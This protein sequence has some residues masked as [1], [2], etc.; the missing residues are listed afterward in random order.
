M[1]EGERGV[2]AT[3]D[4]ST[5]AAAAVSFLP[6]CV[7][8]RF[9]FIIMFVHMCTQWV[10]ARQMKRGRANTTPVLYVP[11]AYRV[12][13]EMDEDFERWG[14]LIPPFSSGSLATDT[15]YLARFL[16]RPLGSFSLLALHAVIL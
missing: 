4:G 11:Y 15:I 9:I 5:A 10:G 12:R 8:R 13:V 16:L 7:C 14:A 6:A 3:A 2:A 1:A